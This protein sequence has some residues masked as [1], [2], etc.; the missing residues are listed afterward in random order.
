[1][2]LGRRAVLAGAVAGAASLVFAEPAGARRILVLGGS[3]FVG[4][5]FV[6]AA[7]A[8]GHHVTLFNRGRSAPGVFPA[9]EELIGDRTGDLSALHGRRFDAVVDTWGK[10]P[11]PVQRTCALLAERTGQYVYISSTSVYDDRGPEAWTEATRV[12][13]IPA[14]GPRTYA[15]NKL[16]SE[17]EVHTYFG[18]RAA[19]VRPAVVVGPYDRSHRFVRWP[20][21]AREG[22]EMLVPGGPDESLPFVD[23]RDLAAWLVHVIEARLS[24]IYNV[25]GALPTI[26][27][28]IDE[29]VARGGETTTPVWV[30]GAWLQA[31]DL[32]FDSMPPLH[33]GGYRRC[34]SA[35]AIAAGLRFRGL[36]MTLDDTLRWWDAQGTG[37]G[38]L[39]TLDRERE[40][41]LLTAWKATR[42]T[43]P[44]GL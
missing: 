15:H 16:A 34:S 28:F 42:L 36:D 5:H 9:A 29:C 43:G 44:G 14:T 2:S 33:A 31:Q 11:G 39:R 20:L 38:E 17:S 32:A 40:Q 37:F 7:L 41:A 23:A 22:G 35:K 3:R 19:I 21:R 26:G 4:L 24:G 18:D 12:D 6:G 27:T 25:A 13:T 30:D 1:M 8:A 10:A